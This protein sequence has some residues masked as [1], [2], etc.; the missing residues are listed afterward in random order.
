MLI[1]MGIL[2]ASGAGALPPAYDLISTSLISTTTA[3][4]TFSSLPTEYTHLQIRWTGRSSRVDYQD[5]TAIRLNG[6]T[7]NTYYSHILRGNGSQ[8]TSSYQDIFNI[9][10][11]TN[12]FDLFASQES[13]NLFGGGIIDIL[14]FNSST[15]RKTVRMLSGI[16]GGTQAREIILTSGINSSSTAALT[17][18]TF[19]PRNGSWLSGS[20]ISIYGIKG[21]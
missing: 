4:V 7:T 10:F 9:I 12:G 8:V 17:S 2:A 15:K 18:I 3:S 5:Q 13:S 14:D 21:A 19:F 6:I 11:P 16:A 20:R 1:P